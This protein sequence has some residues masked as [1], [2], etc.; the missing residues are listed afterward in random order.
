M[1]LRHRRLPPELAPS[2]PVTVALW[3]AALLMAAMM[4]YYAWLIARA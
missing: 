2:W 1:W 3:A 4:A